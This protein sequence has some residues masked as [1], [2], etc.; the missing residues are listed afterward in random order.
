MLDYS[1][2]PENLREGMK[3][4]IEAGILPGNFLTACLENDLIEAVGHTGPPLHLSHWEYLLGVTAFLYNELPDRN[5]KDSPWGSKKAV[6]S[7]ISHK[8]AEKDQS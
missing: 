4:Y 7:W 8:G 5:Y 2:L 3:L 6:N 1:I